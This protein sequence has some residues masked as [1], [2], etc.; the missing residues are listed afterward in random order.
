MSER[1]LTQIRSRYR[2][3]MK[4]LTTA[5]ESVLLGAPPEALATWGLAGIGACTLLYA[6]TSLALPFG[7]DHAIIA[8]VG[9]SYV[10]G[11]LPYVDSWDMKGPAAYLPFA[12]AQILFGPTMWGIRLLDMLAWAVAGFALYNGVRALTTWR[13]GLGA[14][15]AT[16]L[17]IASAGWFFTAAPESWVTA[18]CI[19]AIVPMLSPA[20]TLRLHTLA[21]SG[22]FI[23]CAGLVKPFYFL[24][25]LAP[26]VSVALSSDLSLWRRGELAFALA[27]GA[28]VPPALFGGYFAL[29]GGLSQ[30]IEVH[31]LYPLS[32]YVDVSSGWGTAIH[33]VAAFLLQAPVII[34]VPFV[35]LAIWSQRSQPR[36]LATL[37]AWLGAASICVALQGKY[38]VYHWFPAYPPI[39]ILA[40]FGA[41]TI[42]RVEVR[43]GIGSLTVVACSAL[44]LTA[45]VA[46][47]LRD[48]VR[49]GYYDALK[50]DP[51]S[52]YAA[53][54]F[55]LYNAADEIAVARYLAAHTRPQQ[56]IFVWGSDAPYYLADRPNPSRFTFLMPL[57]LPGAYRAAY[58][59]EAMHALNAHPPAYFVVGIAWDGLSKA[60][61]K[62]ADFPA[63][64]NFLS[65]HYSLEKSIGALDIY[66]RRKELQS[67]GGGTQPRA[68]STASQ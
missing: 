12:L 25:G 38:Y 39:L 36:I 15:L 66:R 41:Y 68:A 30:A 63:M 29:S 4:D 64:A 3:G 40:A 16:Y 42:T 48:V 35:L 28:L 61:A 46:R 13:I 19:L 59:A 11:G 45:V 8:S 52:F 50:Q 10:H 17:W 27:A 14:A 58:R 6:F 55:R 18:S 34:S 49:F 7:W 65:Q 2:G 31:L 33:G 5:I 24:F 23:A 56:G 26:L 60:G 22:F 9:A 57:T 1:D 47:P 21:L 62:L 32:T 37:L 53:Y 51:E 67:A 54:S 43:P 44:V 20:A